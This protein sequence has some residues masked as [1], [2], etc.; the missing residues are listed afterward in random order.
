MVDVAGKVRRP[1]LYRL[2]AGARIDD[3]V[4]AAGGALRG[5]SLSS[6]NLAAKVVDGQQV[7]VG[8]PGAAVVGSTGSPTAGSSAPAAARST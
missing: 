3:A 8:E 2:P 4:R 7:L 1:G 5:A 6:V